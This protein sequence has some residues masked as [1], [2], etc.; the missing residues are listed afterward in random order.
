MMNR[1]HLGNKSLPSIVRICE[2]CNDL[3]STTP[4][5]TIDLCFR[6]ACFG[7]DLQSSKVLDLISKAQ[8]R[9]LRRS[10]LRS[11]TTNSRMGRSCLH[12]TTLQNQT[13]F[14]D[15]AKKS[16]NLTSLQCFHHK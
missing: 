12:T 9:K 13:V 8:V 15:V 11:N 14:A 16:H 3:I 10:T 6:Q 1:I 4:A 7:H 5:N 2:I